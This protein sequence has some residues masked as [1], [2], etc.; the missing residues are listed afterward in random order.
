LRHRLRV[1][2][3]GGPKL[4]RRQAA[5]GAPEA[6]DRDLLG[7]RPVDEPAPGD[8]LGAP[9]ENGPGGRDRRAGEEPGLPAAI[10][11]PVG[12]RRAPGPPGARPLRAHRTA[13]ASSSIGSGAATSSPKSREAIVRNAAG[14][15]VVSWRRVGGATVP[16]GR[17]CPRSPASAA[18]PRVVPGASRPLT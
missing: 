1:R 14:S 17:S 10:V 7:G 2:P 16:V 18:V 8:L 13:A 3:L 12:P 9:A 5:R 11:A 6:G 15:P 4:G